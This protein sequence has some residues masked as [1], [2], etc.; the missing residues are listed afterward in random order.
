MQEIFND[1]EKFLEHDLCRKNNLLIE[2]LGE[3]ELERTKEE[4]SNLKISEIMDIITNQ[5]SD[6]EIS[7]ILAEFLVGEGELCF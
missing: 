7:G 6:D 5:F 3:Y 2:L 4:L 1:I